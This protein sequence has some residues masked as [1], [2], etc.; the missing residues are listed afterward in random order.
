MKRN[1]SPKKNYLMLDDETVF[2]VILPDNE[3]EHTLRYGTEENIY[4]Q[5]LYAASV[6]SAYNNLI[7]ATNERRNKVCNEIKKAIKDDAE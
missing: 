6:I 7:N 3:V 5:R 4:A 2:P 1:W